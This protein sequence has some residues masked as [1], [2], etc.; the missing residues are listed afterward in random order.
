MATGKA[1]DKGDAEAARHVYGP[2]SLAALLPIVVRP[3]LRRRSPAASHLI[4]E[5]EAIV[6]PQVAA[7]SQPRRLFS[8]TLS[9]AAS[10]SGALELQHG[11]AAL[12]ERINAHLGGRAVTRLRFVQ[13]FAPRPPT[14]SPPP[15][16]R[17]ARDAAASAVAHLPPGPLRDALERLGGCVLA[18]DAGP[19]GGA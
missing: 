10:G 16:P 12:L 1:S 18:Q 6:G 11:S 8:G 13:D 15:P 14:A 2:R 7:I 9:I 19:A 17:Q 4:A 5:W 3:A